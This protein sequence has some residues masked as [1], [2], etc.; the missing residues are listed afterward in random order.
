MPTRPRPIDTAP[1]GGAGLYRTDDGGSTWTLVNDEPGVAGNYMARVT[2]HPT[3]PD[4]LWLMGRSMRHST[5]GGQTL[6]Y[7]KGSPGGD[8]YHFL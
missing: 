1:G 2:P 4:E 5:D 3:N 8:D 6:T 7:V